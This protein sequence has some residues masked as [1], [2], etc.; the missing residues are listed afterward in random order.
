MDTKTLY[1]LPKDNTAVLII[2]LSGIILHLVFLSR[3]EFHRDELLYFSLGGHPALGYH[4]VPPLIGLVSWIL[5]HT[6]G[7]SQFAARI[8]PA[9]LGGA[10]IYVAAEITRELN[11]GKFARILTAVSLLCSLIFLRA[12]SMI[13][14]VPFD[15]FFWTLTLYFF[16]RFMNTGTHGPLIWFFITLAVAFLNKYNIIFLAFP[17]GLF[18]LAT[19]YRKLLSNRF[20]YIGLGLAFLIVLPNIIWQVVHQFPVI[21]HMSEL[22]ETQLSK[23]NPLTFLTEQLLIVYPATLIALPGLFYLILSKDL[24]PFRM[25]GIIMLVIV[26]LYLVLQGKSYYA[27]G[28]Y[29]F[30]IAAGSLFFERY[31]RTLVPQ[32]I[33][34]LILLYAGIRILPMGIPVYSP[35]K[36]VAYFDKVEK[37][38][39]NNAIRRYEDNDYHPLP[40][41]YADMLGWNELTEITSQ[42][43]NKSGNKGSCIIFAENYGEAGAITVIGKKYGLPDAISFSDAFR[44]WAPE[45]FSS[46]ITDVIYINGELGGDV[47]QL[48]GKIEEIGRITNPLAR[49]FGVQV[50]LCREPKRSFNQF[51]ADAIKSKK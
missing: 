5:S 39:G 28:I 40:Q 13:Q 51:W 4:S 38:T 3:L 11:G 50:Y 37:N 41:D 44:Y 18:I 27:A 31:L 47:A 46:E 43:W 2:S 22:K 34:L 32:A 25:L 33:V 15:I 10:L 36:L 49:E 20:F 17:M 48:F 7:Y 24:K 16:I 14:P 42:A 30:L 26:L 45:S 21:S 1:R 19:N 23:M 35:E 12:F 8:I 9:F 6:L 29:P